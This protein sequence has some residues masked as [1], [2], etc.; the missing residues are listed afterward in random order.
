MPCAL[1]AVAAG[2]RRFPRGGLSPCSDCPRTTAQSCR[3]GGTLGANTNEPQETVGV[4][5]RQPLWCHCYH[6]HLGLHG[7]SPFLPRLLHAEDLL[8]RI[9]WHT[10]LQGLC[11]CR[12]PWSR[13]ILCLLGHDVMG[14]QLATCPVPDAAD[15]RRRPAADGRMHLP[16]PTRS[17]G[18]HGLDPALFCCLLRGLQRPECAVKR[19][20]FRCHARRRHVFVSDLCLRLLRIC[21]HRGPADVSELWPPC[22]YFKQC[23][24]GP[25]RLYALRPH[26]SHD[27]SG[28]RLH[29]LLLARQV[30]PSS[31]ARCC[32]S[33]PGCC[34]RI[35]RFLDFSVR[36]E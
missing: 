23:R 12:R 14:P 34:A 29:V 31:F 3:C 19:A 25:L 8:G 1:H 20:H 17:A 6:W 21:G 10:H 16:L 18:W 2:R 30:R 28:W 15:Q 24:P 33:C 22:R 26:C 11:S 9:E 35:A 27:A 36:T 32:L 7:G 4:C 13:I 5:A